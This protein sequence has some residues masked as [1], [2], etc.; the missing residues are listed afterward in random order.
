MLKAKE[1]GW[2]KYVLVVILVMY[3]FGEKLLTAE[4]SK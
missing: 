4:T 3:V 2:K 1:L